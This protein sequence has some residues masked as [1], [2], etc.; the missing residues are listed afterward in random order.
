MYVFFWDC[1]PLNS[2]NSLTDV[3]WSS[4]QIIPGILSLIMTWCKFYL[5]FMS[6]PIPGSTSVYIVA[7]TWIYYPT[8]TTWVWEVQGLKCRQ[9]WL[10]KFMLTNTHIP[11]LISLSLSFFSVGQCGRFHQ[12]GVVCTLPSKGCGMAECNVFPFL[13]KSGSIIMRVWVSG[14]I[15][16]RIWNGGSDSVHVVGGALMFIRHFS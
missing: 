13:C 2:R 14:K 11:V 9:L 7:L 12:G 15:G 10:F 1:F 5:I 16:S 6:H 8:G 3:K 4:W